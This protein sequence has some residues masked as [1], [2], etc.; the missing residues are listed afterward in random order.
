MLTDGE[1]PTGKQMQKEWREKILHTTVAVGNYPLQGANAPPESYQ[2]PQGFSVM[3]NV[4]D[5]TD[6]ERIFNS[7][8]HNGRVQMQLQE[9]FWAVRF[10]M[11]V[12]QFGMPW[13]VNCGRPR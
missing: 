5:A 13:T 12:D 8:S 11:I 6:A 9:T 1:S 4:E 2:K 7:L 10:G 3:L